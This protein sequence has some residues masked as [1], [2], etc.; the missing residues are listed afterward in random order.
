[1]ALDPAVAAAGV[2]AA[3]EVVGDAA[4]RAG[5]DP[6]SVELLA[7]VK[8]LPA[9]DLPVLHAAGITRVG[10]NKADALLAKQAVAGELFTWDFIGHLQSR[11][12]RDVVGRVALVHSVESGSTAAQLDRRAEASQDVLVEVNVAA[13]PTKYGVA[14]AALDHFLEHLASLERV[15]VR[16]LMTMP[17]FTER[18]EDSRP[19]FA[20]LRTIADRCAERWAG[21]HNFDVLSM[22]TSQDY[23]VAVEEGATIVRL[24][25]ILYTA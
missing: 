13:D 21:T 10:E 8:Y 6:A 1:V 17:P 3:R 25:S 4:R 16:G 5:R 18:A 2:A 22:G 9:D 15:R 23:V 19:A 20:Q 11:K 7:A 14:P 24:G 12:A